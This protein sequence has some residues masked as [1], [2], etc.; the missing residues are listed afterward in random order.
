MA[1]YHKLY[2]RARYY[3]IALARDVRREV[4]FITEAYGY[5]HGGRLNSILEIACGPGYHAREMARR[6]VHAIG[7]DLEAEMIQFAAAQALSE[8]LKVEWV[9]SDMRQ[10]QLNTPVEM[11][12]CMFDGLDALTEN[13]DLIRH[14]RAVS[15][16]LLPGGLYL[17]DLTH[18]READYAHYAGFRYE[19]ESDGVRV[20][21]IWGINQPR[22][23]LV[24]GVAR[25]EIEI[26]IYERG[27][28]T[29]IRD[30][31]NER[32]LFPQEINLLACLS[33]KMQVIAWHGDYDLRQ[34]LDYSE[35]SKRMIGILQR[36]G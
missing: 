31:A 21:I 12:I 7:L 28:E 20:E 25:S 36:I 32:L 17:I 27:R 15:E 22:Y 1:E 34:P 11:A 14:F 6:G 29:V 26:H 35:S 10:F 30:E 18:P 24:S 19:G 4:D 8:G 13:E 9:V 16:N 5:Y 33:G 3:D 2:Q 23:D